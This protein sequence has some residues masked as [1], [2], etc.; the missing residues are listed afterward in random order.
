MNKERLRQALIEM[1]TAN[2]PAKKAAIIAAISTNESNN[3]FG[4]P[5]SKKLPYPVKC[6]PTR[7]VLI[8]EQGRSNSNV[9]PKT[10]TT[11]SDLMS[12]LEAKKYV[13]TGSNGRYF[14]EAITKY[15]S[16]ET[17]NDD[18]AYLFE[19]LMDQ[20]QDVPLRIFSVGP[21]QI[22]LNLAV[23]TGTP[24]AVKNRFN[25]MD[26]LF[27][28]Y[29]AR[30]AGSL[31][32]VWFDY[33]ATGVAS[34]PTSASKICGAADSN[35]CVEKYLQTYQTGLRDWSDPDMAGYATS[36]LA[37]VQQVTALMKELKYS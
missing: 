20:A 31:F 8:A 6:Y 10:W 34:Y 32:G 33:L 7:Q 9:L 15:D 4:L 2:V 3:T 21:T 25:T 26:D 14:T 23:F 37:S 29:T 27:R 13:Q 18:L 35:A 5:R 1:K 19:F 17:P 24:N 16:F 22:Y 28:F 12:W 11:R 36:F 30:D